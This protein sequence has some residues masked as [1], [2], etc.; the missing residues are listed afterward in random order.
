MNELNDVEKEVFNELKTV[1]LVVGSYPVGELERDYA[2]KKKE[3]DA[4]INYMLNN[5]FITL[6]DEIYKFRRSGWTAL[7]SKQYDSYGDKL[8]KVIIWDLHLLGCRSKVISD[9]LFR[10]DIEYSDR[11]IRRHVTEAGK[12]LK[13]REPTQLGKVLY[14]SY[15]ENSNRRTFGA[16]NGKITNITVQ[17]TESD[18]ESV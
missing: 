12:I 1:F 5:N 7:E 9:I 6:D 2:A 16:A 14:Q 3:C 4:V 11:D 15:L 18:S 8:S 10:I 17:G 13:Y